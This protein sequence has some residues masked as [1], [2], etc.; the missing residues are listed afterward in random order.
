M[1]Q[2]PLLVVQGRPPFRLPK[3]IDGAFLRK[4]VYISVSYGEVEC[5]RDLTNRL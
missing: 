1:T 5:T 2:M 3:T 4:S